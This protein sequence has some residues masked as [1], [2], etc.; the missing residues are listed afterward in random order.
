MAAERHPD[1]DVRIVLDELV[2]AG[3]EVEPSRGG[4]AHPWGS[5][6]CKGGCR[7]SIYGT[8]KGSQGEQAKVLRRMARRCPHGHDPA[9]RR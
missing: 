9:R 4:H 2:E 3:W 7:I 5:A 6:R 8:P 1:K